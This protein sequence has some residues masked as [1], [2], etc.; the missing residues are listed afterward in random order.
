MIKI[1]WII[2]FSLIITTNVLGNT[3]IHGDINKTEVNY[4]EV[5]ICIPIQ[6]AISNCVSEIK[7]KSFIEINE[8]YSWVFLEPSNFTAHLDDSICKYDSELNFDASG[9]NEEIKNFKK[10]MSDRYNL[11]T[12]EKNE[13]Q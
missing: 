4:R 1:I 9:T 5:F 6:E 13:K 3:N 2:L 7:N 8:N 12:E 11:S 10:C